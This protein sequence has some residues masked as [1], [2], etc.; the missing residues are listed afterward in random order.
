MKTD[1]GKN[2]K[3]YREA[4]SL[5]Q[6]ELA[7]RLLVTRQTISNWERGVSLP[8]IDSVKRLAQE[9]HVDAVDILYE[10][11][12]A[13]DF[14][15]SRPKRIKSAVILG[16]IFL[17]SVLLAAILFPY[18]QSLLYQ[19]ISLPHALASVILLPILYASGAAF[20]LALI[21]IWFDFRI[22]SKRGRF[23]M[24]LSSILFFVLCISL[25]LFG[26]SAQYMGISVDAL[27]YYPDVLFDWLF[28]HPV[29]FIL[30]G[31]LLFFG[32]QRKTSAQDK[33]ERASTPFTQEVDIS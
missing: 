12:P 21:A 23:V 16:A 14:L 2:I 18:F 33:P 4:A 20:L 24:I 19:F 29:I 9:F 6:Q 17:G 5:T 11:R 15:A 27:T 7:K 8:D 26:I 22:S 1:A 13:D 10:K 3:K 25:M 28:F 31:A 30:P 32:F